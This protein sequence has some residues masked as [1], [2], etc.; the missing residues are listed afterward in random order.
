MSGNARSTR[1]KREGEAGERRAKAKRIKIAC[2]NFHKQS[3]GNTKP[4]VPGT[5]H[6]F[7]SVRRRTLHV[8]YR[9]LTHHAG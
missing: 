3:T 6:L 7:A 8:A 2:W 9:P 5:A 1:L 4:I